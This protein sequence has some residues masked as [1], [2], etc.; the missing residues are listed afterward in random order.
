[1]SGDLKDGMISIGKAKAE[2]TTFRL[3]L[4]SDFAID[5]DLPF[6]GLGCLDTFAQLCR[7]V[8][9]RIDQCQLNAGTPDSYMISVLLHPWE[10]L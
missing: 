3:I 10:Q 2:E 7:S 6:V 9:S 4:K 8:C 5:H 1:M